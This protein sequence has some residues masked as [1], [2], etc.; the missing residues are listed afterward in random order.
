[1]WSCERN[2]QVDSGEVPRDSDR[3]AALGNRGIRVKEVKQD[4]TKRS[5]CN[6]EPGGSRDF[7]PSLSAIAFEIL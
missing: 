5:S 7:S 4:S 2:H 3:V 6:D 1:M